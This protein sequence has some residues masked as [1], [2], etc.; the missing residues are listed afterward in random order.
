M[1]DKKRTEQKAKAAKPGPE[2]VRLKIDGDLG[3]AVTG[4]VLA[5]KAG[6]G[7]GPRSEIA[8]SPPTPQR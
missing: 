4:I 3:A 7:Q 5:G 1:S 6:G 2:P 8:L